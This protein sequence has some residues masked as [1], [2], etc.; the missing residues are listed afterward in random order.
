MCT[1]VFVMGTSVLSVRCELRRKSDNKN[2][3][4]R[5]SNISLAFRSSHDFPLS[6]RLLPIRSLLAGGKGLGASKCSPESVDDISS[7]IP[8]RLQH[9]LGAVHVT[10]LRGSVTSVRK[11]MQ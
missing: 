3:V 1:V 10:A 6:S 9:F 8:A 7:H 2:P 11:C 5:A 4:A